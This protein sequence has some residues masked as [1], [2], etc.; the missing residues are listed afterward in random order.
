MPRR[1]RRNIRVIK[2]ILR[3]KFDWN[4]SIRQISRSV[5]KGKG[6]TQRLTRKAEEAGLGWPLPED[7]SNE[8]LERLLYPEGEEKTSGGKVV[9]EWEHARR[10]LKRSGVTRQLFWEEYAQD[11]P[12][13]II[14]GITGK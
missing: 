3:L 9:P 6:N 12:G 4:F 11:H 10:E 2:E 8:A 1:R 5:N 14:V 7:V 13:K